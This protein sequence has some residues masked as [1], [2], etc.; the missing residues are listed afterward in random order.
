MAHEFKI[1]DTTGTITTYTDYDDIPLASLLHVISFKP[2]IGTL[3]NGQATCS[4]Q[5]ME[6][7]LVW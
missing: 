2:D 5:Q 4:L 3:V 6:L 7:D 1:M